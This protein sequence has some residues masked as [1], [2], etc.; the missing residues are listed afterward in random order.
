MTPKKRAAEA[1]PP[2]D[3]QLEEIRDAVAG[4]PKYVIDTVQSTILKMTAFP[5]QA[6]FF[7]PGPCAGASE[8]V[9]S[10]FAAYL[11]EMMKVDRKLGALLS[12]PPAATGPD[13]PFGRPLRGVRQA[14][15][16]IAELRKDLG[17]AMESS[18]SFDFQEALTRLRELKKA[19][20]E[21]PAIQGSLRDSGTGTSPTREEALRDFTSVLFELQQMIDF[22]ES[23]LE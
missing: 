21:D 13:L 12:P 11:E 20:R 14:R 6:L 10:T 16:R 23:I 19:V 2:A 8:T 15:R 5:G 18:Q 4:I 22:L 7:P 3:D 9:I 1:K 17:A